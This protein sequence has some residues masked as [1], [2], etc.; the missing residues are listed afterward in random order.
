MSFHENVFDSRRYILDQNIEL[1]IHDITVRI[2]HWHC[3]ASYL[4][5]IIAD[6]PDSIVGRIVHHARARLKIKNKDTI[7][8]QALADPCEDL[9]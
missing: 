8:A 7:F 4:D 3:L 9:N 5:T 2:Q 1:N 6:L